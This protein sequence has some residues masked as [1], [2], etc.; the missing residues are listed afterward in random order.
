MLK[1]LVNHLQPV[2][3]AGACLVASAV[4][5]PAFPQS[6]VNIAGNYRGLMTKCIGV[7]QICRT[8]L[9]ELVRLADEVDVKRAEWEA[10]EAGDDHAA[11]EGKH[12]EY[13]VAMDRLNRGIVNFNYEVAGT[14]KV[15]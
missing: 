7:A 8:A 6:G 2:V 1:M 14:Q 11:A 4:M 9:N 13:A 15:R 12:A 3:V 10:I 5:F